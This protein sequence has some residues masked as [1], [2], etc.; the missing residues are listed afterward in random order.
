MAKRRGSVRKRSPAPTRPALLEPA[1]PRPAHP[2][3]RILAVI[4]ACALI[5]VP[6]AVWLASTVTEPTPYRASLELAA[7]WFLGSQNDFFIRYEYDLAARQWTAEQ[8]PLR[9]LASLWSVAALGNHLPDGRLEAMAQRGFSSFENTF[10]KDESGGFY[11]VDVTPGDVKLGYSA[12]AILSLLEMEH[13]RKDEYLR[14]LA[15]GILSLQGADG[16]FKTFF[17]SD[18]GSGQ[19]YYP[20]EA[21]F[22]LM[23]LYEETGEVRYAEA[24]ANAFMYYRIYWHAS[25]ST[26][27][28]PWQTRAYTRLYRASRDSRVS[29]FLFDMNDWMLKQHD[30]SDASGCSGFDFASKGVAAGV[31]IEGVVEAY[32]LARELNDTARANCYANYVREGLD[33]QLTLQVTGPGNESAALGGFRGGDGKLRVDRTQHAVSAIMG[34]CDAGI[35]ECGI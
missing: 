26:A 19:D 4:A 35:V 13:P 34:A 30:P 5:V 32:S 7:E 27:F 1:S 3:R 12:F 11:Y 33:Y 18:S 21:L 29:S 24:V 2:R 9:E 22:A 17:T 20:G 23:S 31:Y 10:A 6:L 15:D 8:H 25:K 16:A 14:R 28:V